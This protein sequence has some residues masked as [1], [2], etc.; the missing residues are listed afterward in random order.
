ML[1]NRIFYGAFVALCLVFSMVYT[2]KIS[3]IVLIISLLYPFVAAGLTAVQLFSIKAGFSEEHVTVP[4]NTTFEFSLFVKNGSVLPCTPLELECV[5]P[6]SDSGQLVTKR[7]CVSLSPLATAKLVV[8]GKHLYRGCYQALIKR[9]CAIDPLRIIRIPRKIT[10]CMTMIFLPRKLELE[11]AIS[12]SEGDRNISQPHSLTAEREDFSHVRDYKS[13]DNIQLVHWKLTAKQDNMLI[14]QYDT[15]DDKRVLLLCDWC[16]ESEGDSYL[17]TDTI[18]ETALAFVKASLDGGISCNIQLGKPGKFE[19]I[20]VSSMAEFDN[21]YEMMSVIPVSADNASE[22]FLKLADG[23][24]IGNAATAVIITPNLTDEVIFCAEEYSKSAT[25]YLAFVN[26]GLKPVDD[27]LY[28]R[29]FM[30]LNIR[31]SGEEALKLAADM[32]HSAE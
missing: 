28:E 20:S 8:E 6:D 14:K 7:V 24:N 23:M 10:A 29:Q 5:L 31:G 32:M 3:A 1:K 4:K 22:D 21:F 9:V 27:S 15:T 12:S 25:V 16:K 18:I 17:C 26:L 2:S 30:F 19:E 13:G 11:E